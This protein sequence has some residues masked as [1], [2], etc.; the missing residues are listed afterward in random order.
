MQIGLVHHQMEDLLLG[1]VCTSEAT[2]LREIRSKILCLGLSAE[3]EYRAM[4]DTTLKFLC[5]LGFGFISHD[6]VL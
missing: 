3:S 5:G 6:I 1:Y 2:S 4:V